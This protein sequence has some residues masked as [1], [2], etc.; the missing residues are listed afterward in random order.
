MQPRN[1]DY[2]SRVAA[3]LGNANFIRELGLTF[4]DCGPGWCETLLPVEQR[5]WQQD[6]YVHAGVQ[7]TIADHT[8]GCAAATLI[9]A[10]EL[11]LTIEFKLNLLRP[12]VGELLRC[13]AEVLRP[14]RSVVVAESWVYARQGE[15][16]KLCAK[17]TVT[18][19]A[20]PKS[21]PP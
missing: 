5:H 15:T 16:E 14:G 8:A 21:A 17:A 12:A 10:D 18:L 9:G 3:I 13:R 6:A 19:A 7:G 1:P 20:L 2:R 11:I 4:R